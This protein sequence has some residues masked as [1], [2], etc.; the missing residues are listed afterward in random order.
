MDTRTSIPIPR[1][2]Q[3]N[4]P[5]SKQTHTIH[6]IP[7]ILLDI[8]ALSFLFHSHAHT[9]THTRTGT[10]PR[11]FCSCGVPLS[12]PWIQRFAFYIYCTCCISILSNQIRIPFS[13][14]FDELSGYVCVYVAFV[15]VIFF[16]SLSLSFSLTYTNNCLRES[17]CEKCVCDGWAR[18]ILCICFISSM[19]RVI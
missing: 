6:Q 2:K 5:T 3:K 4:T 17:E 10:L 11:F 8:C 1:R 7:M 12:M 9:Q 16:F 18:A 14:L 13:F 19:I 15:C